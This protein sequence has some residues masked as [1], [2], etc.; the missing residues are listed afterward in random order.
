[1]AVSILVVDEA[2][3]MRELWR[4]I[5][6]MQGTTFISPRMASKRATPCYAC[7]PI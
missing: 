6:A 4:S 1:M 5:C 2:R 7:A 3:N